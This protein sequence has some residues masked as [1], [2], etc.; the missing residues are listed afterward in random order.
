MKSKTYSNRKRKPGRMLYANLVFHTKYNRKMLNEMIRERTKE[1][2]SEILRDLG[3]ELL[4][5]KIHPN[6]VHVFIG[7][8]PKLAVAKI[9]NRV[10]GKSSCLLRREFPML[11]DQCPKALWAPKYSIYSK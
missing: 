7:Y 1:I 6:Y 5:I 2:V 11:K 4:K 3:C 10:K 8:H 9:A